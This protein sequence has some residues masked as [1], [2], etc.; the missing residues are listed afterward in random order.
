[1][2]PV[3]LPVYLYFRVTGKA[4][5]RIAGICDDKYMLNE[6]S[7]LAF[8]KYLSHYVGHHQSDVSD[9]KDEPGRGGL[10]RVVEDSEGAR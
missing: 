4:R 2:L 8:K 6:T 9:A 7:D 10:R 1:M 3:T 5:A